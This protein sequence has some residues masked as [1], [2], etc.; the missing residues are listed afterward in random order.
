M[1]SAPSRAIPCGPHSVLDSCRKGGVNHLLIIGAVPGPGQVEGCSSWA[2][3]GVHLESESLFTFIGLSVHLGPDQVF[4]LNQN[5]CSACQTE[6]PPLPEYAIQIH[7]SDIE[8]AFGGSLI[9]DP[10][11]GYNNAR[12]RYSISEGYCSPGENWGSIQDG[13][14]NGMSRLK[15]SLEPYLE[16]I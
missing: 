11:E 4:S 6:C 16:R 8:R 9:W 2:R 5:H 13:I 3:I 10:M 7:Q 12:I 1:G 14:I 15:K